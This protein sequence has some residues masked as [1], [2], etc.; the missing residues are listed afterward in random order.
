MDLKKLANKR[1]CVAISGGV[2][3]V[4]LLHFL[5]T[6]EGVCGFTLSAL[7]CEHGIRGEESLEDMRFVERYC[8]DLG[9]ELTVCETRKNQFGNG[10]AQVPFALF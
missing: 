6:Q 5:K 8:R 9:V 3:S 1:I 10:G 7:H 2:D 4:A